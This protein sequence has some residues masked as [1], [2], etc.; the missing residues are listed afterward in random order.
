M[1]KSFFFSWSFKMT[2]SIFWASHKIQNET[3]IH[4]NKFV[5]LPEFSKSD[6][7]PIGASKPGFDFDVEIGNN[8]IRRRIVQRF[9]ICVSKCE[10]M[11]SWCARINSFVRSYGYAILSLLFFLDYFRWH[12]RSSEHHIKSRMRRR[13]IKSSL[14]ASMRFLSRILSL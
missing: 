7:E 10:L 2:F 4:K 1:Y 12:F 6:F 14:F 5:C 13:F 3:K 11:L 9:R 8:T